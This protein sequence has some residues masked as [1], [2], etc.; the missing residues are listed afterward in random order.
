MMNSQRSGTEKN[1]LIEE[2]K[3]YVFTKLLNTMNLLIRVESRK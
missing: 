1:S 3:K 2:G